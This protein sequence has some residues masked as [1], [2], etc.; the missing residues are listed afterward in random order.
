MDDPWLREGGRHDAQIAYGAQVEGSPLRS[1][2]DTI[3]RDVDIVPS[4]PQGKG[5][6]KAILVQAPRV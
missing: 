5:S 4:A 2:P 6:T 1:I 3:Q